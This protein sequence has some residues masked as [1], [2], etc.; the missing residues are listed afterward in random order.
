MNLGPHAS[1]IVG[2]YAVVAVVV[3]AL[4]CWVIADYRRQ[5]ATLRDLERRGVSRRSARQ[6]SSSS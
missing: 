2:S 6:T 5:R 3:V 1:F 4:I